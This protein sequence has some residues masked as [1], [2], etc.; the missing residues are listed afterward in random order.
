M[1]KFRIVNGK[2]E[3]VSPVDDDDDDDDIDS[4]EKRAHPPSIVS[5][6]FFSESRQIAFLRCENK[7]LYPPVSN[8]TLS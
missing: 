6:F 1:P 2:Y 8:T 5:K 7:V 4:N 3:E